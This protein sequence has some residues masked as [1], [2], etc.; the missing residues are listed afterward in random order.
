MTDM[1]LRIVARA[2]RIRVG[3]GMSL[4]EVL[5]YWP[6]LTDEDKAKVRVMLDVLEGGDGVA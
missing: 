4:D 2:A 1:Q 6:S 5:A 3:L